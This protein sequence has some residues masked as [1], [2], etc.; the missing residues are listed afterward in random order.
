MQ[1]IFGTNVHNMLFTPNPSSLFLDS[2]AHYTSFIVKLSSFFACT[3]VPFN[4]CHN[5]T[6]TVAVTLNYTLIIHYTNLKCK[7]FLILRT[8]YIIYSKIVKFFWIH[9]DSE[10]PPTAED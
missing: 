2:N 10:T 3:T 4:Y 1:E 5:K 8:L 9:H 7:K 6:K